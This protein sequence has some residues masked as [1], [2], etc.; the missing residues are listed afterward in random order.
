MSKR[1]Y[2][3]NLPYTTTDAELKELF[4]AAGVVDSTSIIIDRATS[5]SKGFGFVEMNTEEGGTD[6]IERFN[7]ADFG[8]RALSVSEAR[9]RED[10]TSRDNSG[11]GAE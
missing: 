4:G 10:R 8:G 9:P 5:R 7:Q 1:L 3:G 2:V 6:A 11:A